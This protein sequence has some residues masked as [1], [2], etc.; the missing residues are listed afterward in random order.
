MFKYI[1][2]LTEHNS[3]HAVGINLSFL[4]LLIKS[5]H[6]LIRFLTVD[7]LKCTSGHHFI[8]EVHVFLLLFLQ[9]SSLFLALRDLPDLGERWFNAIRSV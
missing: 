1:L 9:Y 7:L 2:I 4:Q 6:Y 5:F 8:L 3:F